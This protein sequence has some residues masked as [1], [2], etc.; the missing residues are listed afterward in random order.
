MRSKLLDD[1]K[2]H[3]EEIRIASHDEMLSWINMARKLWPLIVVLVLGLAALFSLAKPA[4]PRV[5][6]LAVGH[7]PDYSNTI[8]QK[9]VA[10]FRANGID[11]QL[12]ETE[13]SFDSLRR[14]S[15]DKDPIQAAFV[16]GGIRDTHEAH[17]E[18]MS[19]GSIGYQPLWLFYWGDQEEDD[20]ST[21]HSLLRKKVSIGNLGSGTHQK[22]LDL[23]RLSGMEQGSNMLTLPQKE[24]S[25]AL[26][27]HEIDALLMIESVESPLIQE[28]LDNPKVRVAHFA[29]ARAYAKQLRYLKVLEVPMGS[30]SLIRNHPSRDIDVI[31][32]TTN[33]IIDQNLHPAIQMLFMEASSRIASR[34]GFFSNRR[35]FPDYKDPT[36]PESEVA[37]RFF[38]YGT[39]TLN[40]FLPFWLSDF[41]QRMWLLLIPFVALAYS[42]I[43]TVPEFLGVRRQ[44]RLQRYYTE[45]RRI[46]SQLDEAPD[47]ARIEAALEHLD[48]MEAKLKKSRISRKQVAEF[49]ALRN[50]MMFVRT[51]LERLIPQRQT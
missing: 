11:L 22:A 45:L 4:P 18:L 17:K 6:R 37:H 1:L 50:D 42:L 28:L 35:E 24:A 14:V 10:F 20:Q 49:Y 30:F 12:V 8:A 51:I 2:D 7:P 39:P 46:E 16:E 9:Y 27:R 31:A 32:T 48:Q 44:K 3:A 41:I 13:G 29:R 19:L 40:R 23:L 34:E 38:L 33:I 21:I 15:D 47:R 43:K 36:Y 25:L 5:V 26:Q